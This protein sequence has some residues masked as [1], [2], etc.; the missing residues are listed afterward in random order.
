MFGEEYAQAVEGLGLSPGTLVNYSYTCRQVA[1]SR[2]RPELSFAHHRVVAPLSPEGQRAWLGKAA[3]NTWTR[4]QLAEAVTIERE[5]AEP[6]FEPVTE[7]VDPVELAATQEALELHRLAMEVVRALVDFQ[8][9]LGHSVRCWIR[10]DGEE[11]LDCACG[12]TRLEGA[13]SALG[14]DW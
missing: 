9:E 4:S 3:D 6:T 11:R 5:A 7:V 14:V 2:R 12:L 8:G 10:K 1:R 13:V